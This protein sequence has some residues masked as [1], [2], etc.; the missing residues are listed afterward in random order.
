[1]LIVAIRARVGPL[2]TESRWPPRFHGPDRPFGK[3]RTA[4]NLFDR[5]SAQ[6]GTSPLAVASAAAENSARP[7]SFHSNR[8]VA[9]PLTSNEERPPSS[10]SGM[11]MLP[12]VAADM[13]L[14]V[15][16]RHWK[17]SF[18]SSVAGMLGLFAGAMLQT[19]G[20]IENAGGS[21][22]KPKRRAQPGETLAYRTR[23][24]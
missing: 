2:N 11:A 16:F 5:G 3:R 10:V 19:C 6:R 17:W 4:D 7:S 1:M 8:P 24:A 23:K 20:H 15:V 18:P 22:A 12:I 14:R 21:R 9:G 13:G